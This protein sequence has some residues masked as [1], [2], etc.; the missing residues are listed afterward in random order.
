MQM[1]PRGTGIQIGGAIAVA[2][3]AVFLVR[4]SMM[5]A[6]VAWQLLPDG[7]AWEASRDANG[8]AILPERR[9][10]VSGRGTAG[11]EVT[12]RMRASE[13]GA[14]E[15]TGTAG[16]V[17]AGEWTLVARV[18][19]DAPRRAVVVVRVAPAGAVDATSL[20]LELAR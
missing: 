16:A 20:K 3:C 1:S 19:T 17:A 18:G 12:W 6:Q 11:A 13:D 8:A 4:W 7:S 9:Y 5:P 10:R 15:R 2:V 14:P